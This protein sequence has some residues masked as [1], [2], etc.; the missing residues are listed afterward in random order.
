MFVILLTQ[1]TVGPFKKYSDAQD[2]VID[3]STEA[4]PFE[5]LKLRAEA[6]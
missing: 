4:D 2:W 5:A 3:N 6:S 1:I